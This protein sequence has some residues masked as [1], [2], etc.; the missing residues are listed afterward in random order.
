MCGIGFADLSS[1][2]VLTQT[3]TPTEL[4]GL[5]NEFGAAVADVV[6]ADGAGW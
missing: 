1:F 6:H 4:Q 5:L 3:L 2:T